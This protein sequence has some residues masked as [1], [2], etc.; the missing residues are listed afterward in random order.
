MEIKVEEILHKAFMCEIHFFLIIISRA[1]LV[2]VNECACVCIVLG[3]LYMS[4]WCMYAGFSIFQFSCMLKKCF[5]NCRSFVLY[6]G[7]FGGLHFCLSFVT[8]LADNIWD[9]QYLQFRA[10]E[11]EA[12]LLHLSLQADRRL[13]LYIGATENNGKI[14]ENPE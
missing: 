2:C 6:P 5:S 3:Q 4:G 7:I 10:G 11:P 12:I 14:K 1:H 13:S 8:H 9:S